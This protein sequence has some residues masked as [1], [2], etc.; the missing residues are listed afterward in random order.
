MGLVVALMDIGLSCPY[1]GYYTGVE[2]DVF[3]A[4]Q[5]IRLQCP[6]CLLWYR[7][8]QYTEVRYRVTPLSADD[9]KDGGR[10]PRVR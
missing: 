8:A 5:R 9:S 10:P 3:D 7:V 1:C 4:A 2:D 6:C